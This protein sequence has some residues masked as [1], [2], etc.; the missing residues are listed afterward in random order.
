MLNEQA[1]RDRL[2]ARKA[3]GMTADQYNAHLAQLKADAL[4]DRQR[5]IAE[6]IKAGM[7]GSDSEIDAALAALL[8]K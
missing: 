7:C 4:R 1:L 6:C 8:A 2:A 5:K 3:L